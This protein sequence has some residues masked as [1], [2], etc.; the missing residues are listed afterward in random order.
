MNVHCR[1]CGNPDEDHVADKGC[2]DFAPATFT[3]DFEMSGDGYEWLHKQDGWTPVSSWG[4]DGWDL[5]DWPY[6]IYCIRRI[7][8]QYF[9]CCRV[10]GDLT[11]WRFNSVEARNRFFDHAAFFF[12]KRGHGGPQ[13]MD[14]YDHIDEMPPEY[15]GPYRSHV[16]I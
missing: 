14:E 11:Y 15:F 5:D 12:W 6:V 2:R 16:S 1:N 13:N 10:E 4:A 9:V 7:E 3:F 8:D